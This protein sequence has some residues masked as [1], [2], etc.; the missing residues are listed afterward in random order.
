MTALRS[1]AIDATVNDRNDICVRDE[2]VSGS[3]YKIVN[4]RAYHHGTML[5]SSDLGSLGRLLKVENKDAIQTKGVESVRSPVTNLRAYSDTVTHEAFVSAVVRSFRLDYD[6]DVDEEVQYVEEDTSTINIEYVRHGMDELKTWDW[7]YGQTPEFTHAFD[8][9]FSWGKVSVNV[10][11]KHG[12]ILECSLQGS[13]EAEVMEDDTLRWSE[14][15]VGKKY[16]FIEKDLIRGEM[17]GTDETQRELSHWLMVL[18]QG[19]L[20]Q[21]RKKFRKLKNEVVDLRKKKTKLSEDLDKAREEA[22]ENEAQP[23]RGKRAGPTVASLQ[24]EVASLKTRIEEYEK[25]EKKHNKLIRRLEQ[26]ELKKEADDL[27]DS[28]SETLETDDSAYRLRRLLRCFSDVISAN[29][30]EDGETCPTCYE[31]LKLDESVSLTCQHVMCED[32][33]KKWKPNEDEV[34]CPKCRVKSPRDEVESVRY[35]ASTQWDE[36]LKVAR[37]FAVIDHRGTLDTSEEENEEQFLDDE[38]SE[39]AARSGSVHSEQAEAHP[40][41]SSP[42]PEGELP[43]LPVPRT[44]KK[45]R[46]LATPEESSDADIKEEEP[47]ESAAGPS[48]GLAQEPSYAQSP[49]AAKRR[50]MVE[51]AEARAQKRQKL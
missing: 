7:A 15:L 43:S 40:L 13:D 17:E 51:L 20:N 6:I 44:P 32:C 8:K 31:D 34:D 45:K 10:R 25:S 11:S 22:V 41:S 14:W 42:E 5:I 4:N 49:V 26:K 27:Q 1:L 9:T 28:G 3:A 39:A 19:H 29:S 12:I 37:K 30:L 16:G 46:L 2:K 23:R 50:K 24:K 21:L 35:T 36:L 48:N 38:D 47:D 18:S 33:F